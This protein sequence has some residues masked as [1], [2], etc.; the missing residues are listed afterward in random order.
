MKTLKFLDFI[1]VKTNTNI[2]ICKY[3]KIL[4]LKFDFTYNDFSFII[5][6]NSYDKYELH[7]EFLTHHNKNIKHQ[8]MVD[9]FADQILQ[10][11]HTF[12]IERKKES[13]FDISCKQKEIKKI[14]SI[15]KNFKSFD[16]LIEKYGVF[17]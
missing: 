11:L 7:R 1:F 5:C 2:Y 17:I 14:K 15:E 6:D 10:A 4:N 3:E 12:I 9:K 8:I 13:N 16:S